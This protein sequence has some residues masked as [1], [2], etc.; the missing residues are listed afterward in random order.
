MYL[1]IVPS[2]IR[3]TASST[4]KTGT[5]NHS[6]RSDG[7]SKTVVDFNVQPRGAKHTMNDFLKL[8][9]G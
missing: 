6:V 2:F 4:T 7:I 9:S 8:G 3:S 5:R 1:V